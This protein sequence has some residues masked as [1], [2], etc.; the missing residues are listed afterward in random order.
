MGLAVAATG[1]C[2]TGPLGP[3]VASPSVTASATAPAGTGSDGGAGDGSAVD[4]SRGQR[5]SGRSVS[6][7]PTGSVAVLL[8]AV[9]RLGGTSLEFSL[10]NGV[11]RAEGRY[12][13]WAGATSLVRTQDGRQ[14][15]VDVFGPDLYLTGFTPGR[16]VLRVVA[17]QLPAGSDLLPVAVPLVSLR[18]ITGVVRAE[19]TG[20]VLPSRSARAG[21]ATSASPTTLAPVGT[22]Y[23]GRI[24]LTGVDAG[25]SSTVRRLVTY[26]ITQ[27]G[28]KAGDIPFTAVVDTAGR[29][30]SLRITVPKADAGH[31][32]EIDLAVEAVGTQV[33]VTRPTVG[34]VDAPPA[35]YQG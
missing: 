16:T 24:D 15:E 19:P 13:A 11:R 26:L 18:L 14:V 32:L 12:D 23:A 17:D 2:G 33:S 10:G 21:A 31:D 29:M 30:T 9:G 3:V 4:R 7:S 20:L 8:D 35:F 34:V 27:A 22:S 6:A 5:S 1:C 25:G 28:D